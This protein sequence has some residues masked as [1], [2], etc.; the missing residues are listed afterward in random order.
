MLSIL[1]TDRPYNLTLLSLHQKVQML[2]ETLKNIAISIVIQACLI[3]TMFFSRLFSQQV[4]ESM[5]DFSQGT[6][7]AGVDMEEQLQ[8]ELARKLGIAKKRKKED[9]GM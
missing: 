4:S 5:L 1:S 2:L 6:G 3:A 9:R 8:R 7:K